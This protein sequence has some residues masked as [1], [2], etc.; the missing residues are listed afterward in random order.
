MSGFLDRG[1]RLRDDRE[2]IEARYSNHVEIGQNAFEFLLEFGQL[3]DGGAAKPRI[4]TRI[5]T[6]PFYAK[7]FS[8]LLQES[9]RR[10]E[11]SHGTINGK[12]TGT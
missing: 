12:E 2:Q 7:H 8:D 5:V 1:S 6:S 4:H 3:Y 11:E 10:Y 9:I